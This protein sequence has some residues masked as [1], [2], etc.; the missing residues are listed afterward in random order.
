M[1][2]WV[3]KHVRRY[4][5]GR[6]EQKDQLK[7]AGGE[8]GV[9][10]DSVPSIPGSIS[11]DIDPEPGREILAWSSTILPALSNILLRDE[12]NRKILDIYQK[13]LREE[14]GISQ[15]SNEEAPHYLLRIIDRN[16][17]LIDEQDWKARLGNASVELRKVFNSIAKA[18]QY[19]QSFVGT[20]VSGEPHAALAWAGVSLLLPLLV[21]ASEQPR[22]LIEGID[23]IS[24]MLCQSAVIECLYQ[25]HIDSAPL[26]AIT[27]DTGKLR[28]QFEEDLTMF[29]A[30]VLQYQCRATCQ[31]QSN[32]A[33]RVA[34]DMAKLD[35]WEGMLSELKECEVACDKSRVVLD[36]EKLN[37]EFQ[38]LDD[39][40]K[41]ESCFEYQGY[42]FFQVA[43][44]YNDECALTYLIDL[45]LNPNYELLCYNMTLITW[46][47]CNRRPA[48]VQ[49][50][51]KRGVDVNG[52]RLRG[53]SPLSKVLLFTNSD[54]RIMKVNDND[55]DLSLEFLNSL[56]NHDC[57][58][59][60]LLMAGAETIGSTKLEFMALSDFHDRQKRRRDLG[61]C[62]DTGFYLEKLR[63]VID[64]GSS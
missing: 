7:W 4:K 44:A 18:A 47:I 43:I 37:R 54:L 60:I 42:P 23:Y 35:N 15:S 40:I 12:D 59:G 31:L 8:A 28:S 34:R 33:T 39:A 63:K 20:V 52:S 3:R 26:A 32:K 55:D 6:S 19:A 29:Y 58:V 17:K 14:S 10:G 30:Q 22:S 13:I 9:T 62:T 56:W 16:L 25:E 51:L 64:A 38:N 49:A 53:C 61:V 5:F 46:A 45:G 27:I 50:L 21:N 57:I 41:C 24:R 1:R 36:S 2:S 11:P 48:M